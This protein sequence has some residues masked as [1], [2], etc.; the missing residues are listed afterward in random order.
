MCN[1]SLV[2]WCFVGAVCRSCTVI[3]SLTTCWWTRKDKSK[4]PILASRGTWTPRTRR[5]LLRPL[6]VPSC[7]CRRSVWLENTIRTHP[8]FG[9]SVYLSPRWRWASSLLIQ[10]RV[11]GASLVC[12]TTILCQSS[13]RMSFQRRRATLWRSVSAKTAV[14]AWAPQTCSGTRFWDRYEIIGCVCQSCLCLRWQEWRFWREYPR[15]I[16]PFLCFS[17]PL[18]QSCGAEKFLQLFPPSSE[19][20]KVSDARKMVG[21]LA[22]HFKKERRARRRAVSAPAASII[23]HA[24]KDGLCRQFCWFFPCCWCRNFASS[25]TPGTGEDGPSDRCFANLAKQVGVSSRKLKLY[26]EHRMNLSKS[27][28]KHNVRLPNIHLSWRY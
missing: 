28:G 20:E 11:S 19:A 4:S 12:W 18:L 3:S 24:H 26:F 22:H 14:N 23:Q 5:I 27:S 21:Q 2:F 6:R 1:N 25:Y 15:L 17:R 9:R 10:R 16:S 13:Q 7:T 8:I